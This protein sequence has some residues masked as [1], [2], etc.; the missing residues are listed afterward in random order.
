M[1]Q[2]AVVTGRV[3]EVLDDVQPDMRE[4]LTSEPGFAKHFMDN[5]Q[6]FA[7]M[8]FNLPLVLKGMARISQTGHYLD[9]YACN[10]TVS[11][12][13]RIDSLIAAIIREGTPGDG[14]K[15]SRKCR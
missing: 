2:V 12:F 15:Q 5:K 13:P 3:A 4:W 8:A 7:Y 14:P 10:I 6:A 1:Q 11:Q 9:I